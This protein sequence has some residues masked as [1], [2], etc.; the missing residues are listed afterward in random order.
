M[1][2]LTAGV[3]G[4]GKTKEFIER[5]NKAAGKTDGHIVYIDRGNERMYDLTHSV[6]LVSADSFTMTS[7]GEFLGFIYGVL[8]QDS[9]IKEIYADSL[10]NIVS[11]AAPGDLDDFLPKLEKFSL[12]RGVDFY[13]GVGFSEE[14][15][16]LG[17]K[18]FLG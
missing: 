17:A 16:T 13:I 14:E 1:I 15:I 4:S 11:A 5:A 8:S 18:K 3:K 7:C 9:D 6:R 12:E 10:T 2:R